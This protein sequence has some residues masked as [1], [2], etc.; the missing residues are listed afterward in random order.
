MTLP[1]LQALS[2]RLSYSAKAPLCRPSC[3]SDTAR[4]EA[5][6]TYHT[7]GGCAA[8]RARAEEGSALEDDEAALLQEEDVLALEADAWA[9]EP[10]EA[11]DEAE[12][13]FNVK[14]LRP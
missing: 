5:P 14:P 3:R 13:R 12:V 6:H 10:E 2:C 4:H 9:S 8:A 1:V 11:A 7:A